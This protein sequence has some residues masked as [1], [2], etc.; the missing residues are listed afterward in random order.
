M[1]PL[2]VATQEGHDQLAGLLQ[3]RG[4]KRAGELPN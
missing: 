1:T 2:D 4:A 3:S